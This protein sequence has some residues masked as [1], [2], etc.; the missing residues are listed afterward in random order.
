[1]KTK[2][3]YGIGGT[4]GG[5]VGTGLAA[6]PGVGP[7]ISAL[8]APAL[9][10]LGDS[11]EEGI[12]K[13]K[14]KNQNTGNVDIP[15]V[16]ANL[17]GN[18]QMMKY[19][20]K[21]KLVSIKGPSH[22]NGGVPLRDKDGKTI[23]EVEGGETKVVHNGQPKFI[24]SDS[25]AVPNTNKSFAQ[26]SKMMKNKPMSLN[27]LAELQESLKG[28][29]NTN[30]YQ[31]GGEVKKSPP[32]DRT[33]S[34][35][36]KW[37]KEYYDPLGLKYIKRA[38]TDNPYER[39]W[40]EGTEVKLKPRPTSTSKPVRKAVPKVTTPPPTTNKVVSEK[41]TQPVQAVTPRKAITAPPKRVDITP[42][43]SK[44]TLVPTKSITMPEMNTT[45]RELPVTEPSTIDVDIKDRS[46][47][48]AI[49]PIGVGAIQL[50]AFTKNKMPR[51]QENKGFDTARALMPTRFSLDAARA[52]VQQSERNANQLI[53]RSTTNSGMAISAML[54]NRNRSNEAYN[55]IAD[56]E[57]RGQAELDTKR[58]NLEIS[59]GADKQNIKNTIA[60][61]D[62]QRR[63]GA[64][65]T[66]A[67]TVTQAATNYF[68]GK[69]E[70]EYLNVLKKL[71]RPGAA[72]ALGIG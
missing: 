70:N 62:S 24:F 52:D 7:I 69:S 49:A 46:M 22:E 20:G 17:M 66:V 33:S 67:N 15:T 32:K 2:P 58:A 50:A 5:I 38:F 57:T 47:L 25:I 35:Y 29:S 59:A 39:D 34:E 36:A 14:N 8:A 16:S 63:Q 9:S 45:K 11:I 55:N 68:T 48:Q 72:K 6:I 23:G 44:T 61:L 28:N 54:S 1:M 41:P 26:M 21:P 56:A 3:K 71:G 31:E 27:T 12:I 43:E 30:M 18:T 19:G 13:K 60:T 65:N 4:I 64:V 51:L 42:M 10:T 53:G 37:F 40:W